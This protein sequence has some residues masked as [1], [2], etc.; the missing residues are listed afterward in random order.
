[1]RRSHIRSLSA[2]AVYSRVEV[3]SAMAVTAVS[4]PRTAALAPDAPDDLKLLFH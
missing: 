3:A 1:M 4:P 2:A